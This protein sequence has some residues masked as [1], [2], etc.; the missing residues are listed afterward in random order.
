M[1]ADDGSVW[2]DECNYQ[3]FKNV[4]TDGELHFCNDICRDIYEGERGIP[5]YQW[6]KTEGD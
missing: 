1:K 4:V 3:V 5:P 2:C 6:R